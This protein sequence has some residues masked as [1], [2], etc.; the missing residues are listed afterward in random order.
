M[1]IKPPTAMKKGGDRAIPEGEQEIA[2]DKQDKPKYEEFSSNSLRLR[3]LETILTDKVQIDDPF[4][5]ALNKRYLNE[6]IAHYR[7]M[8]C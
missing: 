2:K 7:G 6:V 8:D 3:L 5:A 1:K 4:Y